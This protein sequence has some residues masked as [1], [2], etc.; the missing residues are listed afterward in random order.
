MSAS[1]L[2]QLLRSWRGSDCAVEAELVAQ[3]YPEIH[4]VAE[5]QLFKFPGIRTLQTTEVVHEA[6]ERMR[7]KNY[8][9]LSDRSHFYAIAATIIRHLL[10]DHLR[11]KTSQKRGDGIGNASLDEAIRAEEDTSGTSPHTTVDWLEVDQALTQLG[12]EDP[13]TAR[14]VE[15]R[16]FGG[17]TTSEIAE[18]MDLSEATV[19]RHWRFARAFLGTLLS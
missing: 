14:I 7:R 6:F 2:T 4:R 12:K 18:V 1:N 16:V 15:M 19:G 9:E 10:V 8:T 13:T 17:L 11:A 3:I 5:L